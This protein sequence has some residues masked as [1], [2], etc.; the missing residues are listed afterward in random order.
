MI[1]ISGYQ[2]K[3]LQNEPK[4]LL[5]Q[6]IPQPPKTLLLKKLKG[7]ILFMSYVCF[8]TFIFVHK[9]IYIFKLLLDYHPKVLAYKK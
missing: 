8:Y 3:T 2:M 1:G 5:N 6:V 9:D 7:S 4:V